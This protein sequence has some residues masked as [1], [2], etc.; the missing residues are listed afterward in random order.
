MARRTLL[1]AAAC[2]AACAGLSAAGHGAVPPGATQAPA[3]RLL[4]S[5]GVASAAARLAANPRVTVSDI[6]R[7]A[8]GRPIVLIAITAP[9]GSLDDWKRRAR[10]LAGP[11]VHYSTLADRTAD[12]TPLAEALEGVRLPVLLAGASWGHEAAQVEGLLAAAEH[13]ASDQSAD[14]LRLLSRVVV[15]IVPLMNPDGRDRAIA[16]W[17]RTPLSNGD[18]GVGNDNGFMLNRDFVHQTQPE[19]AALLDLVR[20]W[21]PVI[22]IDEHEDVNRLGLAVPEVAFVPPYMPGFDV[23]EEP[24][25]R[26]AI[27]AVGG[28]IADRW[29]QAGY[30]VVHD[31]EGDRRW[32]PLPPRGSGE[33]NPVA[34]SSGRLDFLFNI[35]SVV[36]LITESAR[37]PGTQT[38]NAR[39]EQKTLAAFAAAE[40]AAARSE[41]LAETIRARRSAVAG[42][43]SAFV[44]IPHAQPP[45]ADRTELLRLLRAHDVLVYRAGG[46]PYDVIPLA[47]PEAPFVRHAVLAERSKLN[48][49]PAALGVAIVRGDALDSDT[50]RQVTTAP[51]DLYPRTAPAWPRAASP[52]RV[53]VYTG[54]GIDRAASGEVLFVLRQ[55]GVACDTIDEAGVRAGRFNN[56]SAVVFGD[57]AA[58]EIVGGWDQ[59]VATRKTPWQPAAPSRGIGPEGVQALAAFARSGGRVV[60]IGRSGGLVAP[61]FIDLRLPPILPGIG[62]V[63]LEI[64]AAGR[65]FFGA[66][67][68]DS[69]AFLSAPPGGSDGGY[70]LEAGPRA[71]VL[72][73]YAGA[74]DRPAE[75]SFADTRPLLRP[76]RHAAIAAAALGRGR[77]VVFGFSPVFRAQWRR[78]FPLLFAA[79]GAQ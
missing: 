65:T 61:A 52:A 41:F 9:G 60:T 50:R 10:R 8:G 7:S 18:S 5:A 15:L 53:A 23:E 38:W 31:P 54:Q 13:L 14:T 64:T 51:L 6:G 40:T 72:A 68:A 67:P 62:E 34:G 55:A 29:R 63:R 36:G 69:R 42:D 43:P 45:G 39:V 28:A 44:A 79:V 74:D 24:G 48:D 78:T 56:A 12:E 22:G 66:R 27:V 25:M 59:S 58:R 33:I 32:V 16:E 57:G 2:L 37:T 17:Q 4:D 21:R 73:W 47:Q 46:L 26:R 76:A 49:L 20:D 75:Q 35:H 70:L 71:E 3:S 1:S 30:Q 19:T 77:I 11:E